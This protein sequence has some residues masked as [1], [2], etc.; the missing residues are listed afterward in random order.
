MSTH[1]HTHTQIACADTAEYG[2]MFDKK[3]K[4]KNNCQNYT[5]NDLLPIHYTVHSN[6]S[7]R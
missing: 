3:D 6:L 1:T 7:M 5:L 2:F 4:E